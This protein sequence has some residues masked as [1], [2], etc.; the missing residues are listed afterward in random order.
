MCATKNGT[1]L[2][3]CSEDGSLCM[4]EVK[5]FTAKTEYPDDVLVNWTEMKNKSEEIK[6]VKEEVN[7]V[8][9]ET[10]LAMDKLRSEKEEEIEKMKNEN[11]K[12]YH[13]ETGKKKVIALVEKIILILI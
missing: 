1:A 12:N 7:K 4:W 10:A 13:N 9:M 11:L 5:G 8:K 6:R 2:I 3:S